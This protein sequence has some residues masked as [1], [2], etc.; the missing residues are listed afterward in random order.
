MPSV[1]AS[2]SP[3]GIYLCFVIRRSQLEAIVRVSEAL[4]KLTLSSVATEAHVDEALRLFRVSTMQ[5]VLAGH[6]LEGMTRPDLIKQVDAVERAICQRLSVGARSD[7]QTLI[8]E[9]TQ[10]KVLPS[11]STSNTIHLGLL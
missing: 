6:S 1:A 10:S 4:A 3:S 5:A 11:S 8:R 2:P 7:V 9:L